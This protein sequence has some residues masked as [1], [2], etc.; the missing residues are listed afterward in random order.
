[1]ARVVGF[2]VLTV[3]AVLAGMSLCCYSLQVSFNVVL[4]SFL[5]GYFA[6]RSRENTSLFSH[7]VKMA[8]T[9][10]ILS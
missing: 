5:R 8:L 1:M 3:A 7:S 9:W 2:S 6:W 10:V 4:V